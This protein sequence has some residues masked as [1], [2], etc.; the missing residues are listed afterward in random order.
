MTDTGYFSTEHDRLAFKDSNEY[1]F[2]L[3]ELTAHS[4][5]SD[6]AG[7]P[8]SS[9]HFKDFHHIDISQ[10]E[11]LSSETH[12]FLMTALIGGF[13]LYDK[14]WRVFRVDLLADVQQREAMDDLIINPDNRT[15]VEAIVCTQ[16]QPFQ[17][18]SMDNKGEG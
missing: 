1:P 6:M 14:I 2:L 5:E 16:A 10:I 18:D 15:F 4:Y 13:G 17:I 7:I 8:L 12:Y 3:N 9:F 11:E